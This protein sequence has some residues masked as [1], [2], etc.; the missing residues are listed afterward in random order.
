MWPA[1]MLSQFGFIARI[2]KHRMTRFSKMNANLVA[3]PCFEPHLHERRTVE[4]GDDAEMRDR[5]LP[6]RFV[7]SREPFE[8][9]VR[10]QQAF[11]CSLLLLHVPSD[12]SHVLS[13]RLARRKLVLQLPHDLLR[14]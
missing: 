12:D 3:S 6:N 7:L 4:I 5:Q 9:L 2:T 11:K 13:F 10:R 14:L 1:W 8:I